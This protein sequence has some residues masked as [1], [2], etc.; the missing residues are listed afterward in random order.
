MKLFLVA[1]CIAICAPL[2]ANSQNVNKKP[3]KFPSDL[4]KKFQPP[5]TEIQDEE[6]T[7]LKNPSQ[8]FENKKDDKPEF[9]TDKPKITPS[10]SESTFEEDERWFSDSFFPFD[11][12]NDGTLDDNGNEDQD[13]VVDVFHDA[14]SADFQFHYDQFP[15]SS[16]SES[17]SE[18]ESESKSESKSEFESEFESES[19]SKS[20]EIQTAIVPEGRPITD[21]SKID[22]EPIKTTVKSSEP[23][24][25]TTPKE[26][27]HEEPTNF[28]YVPDTSSYASSESSVSDTF[29]EWKDFHDEKGL[30]H[31]E[32]SKE[33]IPESDFSV[34]KID[35]LKD[36][37]VPNPSFEGDTLVPIE[38]SERD[39]S[40]IEV[41]MPITKNSGFHD[42]DGEGFLTTE[43]PPFDTNLEKPDY[44][45]Y[46]ITKPMTP[47]IP[48]TESPL[49]TSYDVAVPFV[50]SSEKVVASQEK[51]STS[52]TPHAESDARVDSIESEDNVEI[53]SAHEY[54]TEPGTNS[55][56]YNEIPRDDQPKKFMRFSLVTF[57]RSLF[58]SIPLI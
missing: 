48:A 9:V 34:E 4:Y 14:L 24:L 41:L 50:E 29:S 26:I 25:P 12:I 38:S 39:Y 49:D 57:L 42:T 33:E 23:E 32:N 2:I 46:G 35:R 27:P 43:R 47:T 21:H 20:D 28:E 10:S 31:T 11:S 3:K 52:T 13:K 40:D 1:I 51:P 17:K 8:T 45:E 16:D 55:D 18:F 15:L 22:D 7:K 56:E 19:D 58:E 53:D 6:K 5:K 44:E 54:Q 36:E 37:G 30:L